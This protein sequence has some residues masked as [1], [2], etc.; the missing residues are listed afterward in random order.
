MHADSF[1]KLTCL[2]FFQNTFKANSSLRTRCEKSHSVWFRDNPRCKH[3]CHSAAAGVNN[4]SCP[5]RFLS[6]KAHG[7]LQ[8]RCSTCETK[9]ACKGLHSPSSNSAMY[10]CSA[11]DVFETPFPRA[12]CQ[13]AIHVN[14]SWTTFSRASWYARRTC[15]GRL[16]VFQAPSLG[17]PFSRVYF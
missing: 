9:R 12:H 3:F 2:S 8:K 14:G 15:A 1:S 13:C 11:S 16:H 4:N 17:R 7:L 10:V 6:N 5:S